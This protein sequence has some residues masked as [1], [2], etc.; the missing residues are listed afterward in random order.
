MGLDG[1]P[2]VTCDGSEVLQHKGWL[3]GSVSGHRIIEYHDLEGI[4][5]VQLL[6]C[7]GQPQDTRSDGPG[8][9]CTKDVSVSMMLQTFVAASGRNGLKIKSSHAGDQPEAA[10][11]SYSE[12]E[13]GLKPVFFL[14]WKGWCLCA[15]L[16]AGLAAHSGVRQPLTA[17][18]GP[19]GRAG[20]QG[21]NARFFIP[22]TH[23]SPALLTHGS[24]HR[25]R[26]GEQRASRCPLQLILQHRDP[27]TGLFS[28]RSG[29]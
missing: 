10:T 18:Q 7:T 17:L 23:L 22:R 5:E 2:A 28:S 20:E 9:G 4:C 24:N 14:T 25:F 13:L 15:N 12:I 3:A 19:G 16:C 11:S 8:R 21:Q 26:P 29:G 27:G 1:S 6:S